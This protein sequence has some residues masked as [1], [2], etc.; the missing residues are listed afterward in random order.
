MVHSKESNA[1]GY[2]RPPKSGVHKNTE[3]FTKML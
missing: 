2:V 1:T 3:P